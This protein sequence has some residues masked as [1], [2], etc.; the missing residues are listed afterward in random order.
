[1][2]SRGRLDR[3]VALDAIHEDDDRLSLAP[4]EDA[5]GA[6]AQAVA[7]D[8]AQRL[9]PG[10]QRLEEERLVERPAE[11]PG[12]LLVVPAGPLRVE[13]AGRPLVIGGLEAAPVLVVGPGHGV[14]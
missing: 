3:R 5:G 4:R 1:M 13:L 11:G 9:R 14:A 12:E 2:E 8:Q 7:D 6:R 10:R